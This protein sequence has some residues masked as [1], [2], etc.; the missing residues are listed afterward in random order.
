VIDVSWEDAQAYA[1]WLSHATGKSY[2]LPTEAEWEYAARSGD[3]QQTWAGTSEE[4][5]LTKY[6][7]YSNNSGGK[8]AEVGSRE[9]NGLELYDMSGNVREWV[10]DC[11][12]KNYTDA[13][14]DGSAWLREGGA[15]GRRVIRGGSWNDRPGYLRSSFRSR[16][17]PDFRGNFI[18][19]RLAQ[20]A[21]TADGRVRSRPV[22]GQAG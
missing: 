11:W 2:R 16:F 15:C 21:R 1:R 9:P 17:G 18:G 12:H 7:V 13:P 4:N 6:A 20:S 3:K 22:Y 8:T 10:E 5:E 19:F 14:K